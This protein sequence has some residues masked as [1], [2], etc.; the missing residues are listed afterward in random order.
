MDSER[1]ASAHRADGGV[2]AVPATASTRTAI[3]RFNLNSRFLATPEL[4]LWEA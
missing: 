2:S 4:G 3:I 1:L